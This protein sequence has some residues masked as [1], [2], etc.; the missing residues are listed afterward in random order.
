MTNKEWQQRERSLVKAAKD[1]FQGRTIVDV[2]YLTDEEAKELGWYDRCVV[3]Q[4]DNG[5]LMFPSQDEEGNNAGVI[6]FGTNGVAPALP[7]LT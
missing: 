1:V 6:F 3:F 7:V 5:E 4:L 2:R